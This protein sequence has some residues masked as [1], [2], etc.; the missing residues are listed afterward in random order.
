MIFYSMEQCAQC[1]QTEILLE[2]AG[3]L[4]TKTIVH[5]PAARAQ[6][7][8]QYDADTFPILVQPDGTV[9][10]GYQGAIDLVDLAFNVSF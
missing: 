10:V 5:D 8:L 2:E 9:Y 1:L 6:L 7:R 3:V 4:F